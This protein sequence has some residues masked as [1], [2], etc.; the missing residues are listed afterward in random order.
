MSS[1]KSFD[2]IDKIAHNLRIVCGDKNAKSL[3][4]NC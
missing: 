1:S 4:N 3:G 2:L